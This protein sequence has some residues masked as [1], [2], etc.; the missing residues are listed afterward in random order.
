MLALIRGEVDAIYVAG[1][2]GPDLEALLD[3]DVVFDIA[4]QDDPALKI[5]NITPAA[6]TVSGALLDE[7]PTSSP[8][9]SPPRCA[10][11]AGRPSTPRETRRIIAHEVGI[12]EDFVEPGYPRA[13]HAHLEPSLDEDLVAAIE[14][15]QAFLLEHGYIESAFD[16]REWIDAGPLAAAPRAGG[17][18]NAAAPALPRAP[19]APPSR[20]P[21]AAPTTRAARTAAG[22]R[23][24]GGDDA[25]T[26]TVGVPRS[27]GYLSTL[28]ARDVQPEG[29]KVEYK[30]F[31]VFT[32]MLTALNSGKI[33][34]T[35]IG[36]VGAVQSFANGGN[37]RAVA[38]TEP[39]AENCGLLVPKDSPAQ[40]VRRPQGQ[41]DRVPE[42]DEL[43]HLV[44]APGQGGRAGGERL[45]DRRDHRAAGQQGVP[46]RAS[47]T[48]YY[49]IDPNMA[50]LVEQT[51]GRIISTL[52]GR[53]RREPLPVRRDD[54][55]RSR[56]SGTR[57]A[58]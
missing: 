22:V 16:V 5:N 2:R 9:T 45:P 19:G 6:L 24:R 12:A 21:R 13:I 47:S 33:D 49:S 23:A 57:S 46:D 26:L 42:V 30:Y 27:F 44:P 48:R 58:R 4:G 36:S 43:L 31:P 8:A 51:G 52:R 14:S 25:V 41:E 28:W 20:S 38:V 55:R 7:R 35:E 56:T 17:A 29:V 54:R 15:Q 37:V 50:D 40:S 10:R 18:M 3:V 11:R 32:D 34:L 1:G 53:R 39:N